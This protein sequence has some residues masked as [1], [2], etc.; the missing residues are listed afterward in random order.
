MVED[1]Y[2]FDKPLCLFCEKP[3]KSLGKHTEFTCEDPPLRFC[4]NPNC[5]RFGVVTIACR[6]PLKEEERKRLTKENGDDRDAEI[7][8]R[9]TSVGSG[10]D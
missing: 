8:I 2:D 5:Q 4:N 1:K 3:L 10:R 6:F 9:D 7:Q